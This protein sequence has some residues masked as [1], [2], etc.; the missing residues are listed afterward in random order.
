MS[1]VD[2]RLQDLRRRVAQGEPGARVALLAE[3]LRTGDLT[4]ERLELAAFVGD[5]DARRALPAAP[6]LDAAQW[7]LLRPFGLEAVVRS[8]IAAGWLAATSDGRRG[9]TDLLNGVQRTL[10]CPCEAH[11]TEVRWAREGTLDGWPHLLRVAVGSNVEWDGQTAAAI[12][13]LSQLAVGRT[14]D[15]LAAIRNEVAPW[16]LGERDLVRERVEAERDPVRE[17][18]LAA[19]RAGSPAARHVARDINP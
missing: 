8:A 12:L 14:P 16:A 4:R 10:L 2:E 19:L 13:A 18:F 9:A 17:A 1:L 15:V 6:V 5:E 3:R 11:R 7:D